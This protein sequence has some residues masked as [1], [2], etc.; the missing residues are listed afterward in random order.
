MAALDTRDD[1]ATDFRNPLD[2]L[3]GYQLRRATT[4]ML[5]DLMESLNGTGL[6]PSEASV[7]FLIEAN[8]RITQSDIGRILG[9]QRA[10]MVPL[11]ARL[12]EDALIERVPVDGRSHGLRLTKA[13]RAKTRA[14]AARIAHHEKRF[15]APLS[16]EECRTLRA[17]LRRL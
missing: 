8:P 16:E 6:R 2:L 17:M 13:G 5:A 1:T 4:A 9:V 7:L 11:I 14:V 10:N 3:N 12:D 15:F